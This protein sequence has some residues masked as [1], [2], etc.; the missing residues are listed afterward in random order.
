M[1]KVVGKYDVVLYENLDELLENYV[2]CAELGSGSC[3]LIKVEES[4]TWE[5]EVI[6][7]A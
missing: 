7:R 2:Y 5:K 3:N 6:Y 4:K 1:S